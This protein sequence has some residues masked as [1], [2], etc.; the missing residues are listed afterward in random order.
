MGGD[1]GPFGDPGGDAAPADDAD[2]EEQ[3]AE[4]PAA[5][6][7]RR[8]NAPTAKEVEEHGDLHEPYRAWCPSCI[9]GRGLSDRHAVADTSEEALARVGLDYGYLGSEEDATP[10]LCGRDSKHRRYY[11]IAVS[12]KG[13][14]GYAVKRTTDELH[15]AGTS[16]LC[17]SRTLSDRWWL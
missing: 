8:P 1:D 15:L 6:P 14:A 17:Y 2:V 9:A 16:G 5:K 10:L 3:A 11:A 4:V 13:E 12:R 7:R